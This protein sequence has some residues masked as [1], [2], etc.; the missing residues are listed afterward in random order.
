MDEDQGGTRW[1]EVLAKATAMLAMHAAKLDDDLLL[2][3]KFLEGLGVK[4][5]EAAA[6]LGV[7]ASSLRAAKSRASK[8]GGRRG[9]DNK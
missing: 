9:K 3:A 4:A 8:D 2:R 7:A 1:A 5:P 6:M